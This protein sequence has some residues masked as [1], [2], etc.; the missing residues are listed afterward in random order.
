MNLDVGIIMWHVSLYLTISRV[1]IDTDWLKRK[2]SIIAFKGFIIDSSCFITT[3][4]EV[5]IKQRSAH[6]VLEICIV[7]GR[8]LLMDLLMIE[9][10]VP[11]M[12]K[13]TVI[14]NLLYL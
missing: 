11:A 4:E 12:L 6:P 10:I 9:A 8:L 13:T 14:G 7:K 3:V 1:L 2:Y 5:K